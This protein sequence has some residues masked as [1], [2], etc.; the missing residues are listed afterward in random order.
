MREVFEEPAERPILEFSEPVRAQLY[1]ALR[2]PIPKDIKDEIIF[3]SPIIRTREFIYY[4]QEFGSY[5]C[6]WTT[7]GPMILDRLMMSAAGLPVTARTEARI[8]AVQQV[9]WWWPMRGAVV[10][11]DRP[12]T[13]NRDDSTTIVSY[14][15]GFEV[16]R[17]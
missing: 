10:L 8:E 7:L 11:T 9:A 14:A 2:G 6:P 1:N 3:Y 15:D 13:L 5:L 12:L 4:E 16:H 17:R